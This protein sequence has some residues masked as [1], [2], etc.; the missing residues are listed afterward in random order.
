MIMIAT[1]GWIIIIAAVLHRPYI[2]LSKWFAKPVITPP[3]VIPHQ[4]ILDKKCHD[5]LTGDHW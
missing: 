4:E 1:F 3:I 5:Y 2:L